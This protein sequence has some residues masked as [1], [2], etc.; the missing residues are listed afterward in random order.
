VESADDL[1]PGD[2]IETRTETNA[3]RDGFVVCN[4][5]GRGAVEAALSIHHGLL[6]LGLDSVLGGRQE[7]LDRAT[8][9]TKIAFIT[10][11][12]SEFPD[13][14]R[15]DTWKAVLREPD[16]VYQMEQ[17]RPGSLERHGLDGIVRERTVWDF[18]AANVAYLEQYGARRA[19]HVP[20]AASS[21]QVPMREGFD[22]FDVVFYG[23]LS[24]R[25]AAVL[26][27]LKHHGLKCAFFDQHSPVWGVARDAFVSCSKIF[28]NLHFHSYSSFESFRCIAPLTNGQCVISERSRLPD[29]DAPYLEGVHFVDYDDVVS[30]CRDF[31]DRSQPIADQRHRAG[32]WARRVRQHGFVARALGLP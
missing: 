8:P 17:L 13:L 4:V 1:S 21:A 23:V 10:R 19:I 7:F 6:D 3:P 9:R 14:V 12:S 11:F 24:D 32:L 18:S 31:V 29:D 22:H 15:D 20:L 27:Q 30:T 25:R 26:N 28:L 16:I 2:D 5:G